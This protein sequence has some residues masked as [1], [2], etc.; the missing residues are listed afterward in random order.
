MFSMQQTG[1]LEMRR[2]QLRDG[3]EMSGLCWE[4]AAMDG[5]SRMDGPELIYRGRVC[6]CGNFAY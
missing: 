6:F 2:E 3:E 4:R 1:M 5:W